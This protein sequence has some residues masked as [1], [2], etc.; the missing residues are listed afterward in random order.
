MGV[1]NETWFFEIGYKIHPLLTSYVIPVSFLVLFVIIN[2]VSFFL[3]QS[4]QKRVLNRLLLDNAYKGSVTQ[5]GKKQ[6]T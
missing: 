6:T 1:S 4:F 2:F 3:K 5:V